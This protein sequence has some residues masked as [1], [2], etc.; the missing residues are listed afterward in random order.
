M[1]KFTFTKVSLLILF[2]TFVFLNVNSQTKTYGLI[3]KFS[4]SQ[5]NGYVLYS[6]FLSDTTFLINKC[7]Q[8]VHTWVN[9]SSPGMSLYL[10]PNGNLLKTG[11]YKD[12][13]FNHAGGKAGLIEEYDWDGNL[14]WKYVVMNDSLLHHHDIEI[15]PNGNI[16]VLAWH[17]ISEARALALGRKPEN[18]EYGTDKK[19]LWGEKIIEIKPLGTDSAEVVW[20]WDLFDHLIQDF[21]PLLPNFGFPS[22]FP[23]LM[24]INYALDLETFDWIHA[25][26]VAYNAELDQIVISAH[27]ICEF[28]II[29]HSTTIAESKSHSGGRYNKGGD[30][31]FRWGNPMAY[32]HGTIADRKL[33]RQ[34]DAHWIP[35]GYLDEG[36]IMLFNNGWG[37][38]TAYSTVEVIDIPDLSNNNY[39]YNL[40]MGP[41]SAHWKYKDSNPTNFYSQIIS[42][43]R[44]LPNGNTLICEGT[45]SLFFEVTPKGKIVWKYK[46]PYIGNVIQ[47]DGT[48]PKNGFVFR[49]SFYP[50]TFSGFKNKELSPKGTIEKKPLPYSCIYG[51]QEPKLVSLNPHLQKVNVM[52]NAKLVMRFDR[53]MI[54]G[55]NGVIEIY[56]NDLYHENILVNSQNVVMDNKNA[57]ITPS[58]P[59]PLNANIKV[60]VPA[61]SFKDSVGLFYSKI[62]SVSDWTFSTIEALPEITSFSPLHTQTNV[63]RNAKLIIDFKDSIFKGNGNIKVYE[64]Y[65][66]KEIINVNSN[67][68][69]IIGNKVII[70]LTDSFMPNHFV[71]VETDSCFR[72]E[73]G[74]KS[75]PITY[76]SWFFKTLDLLKPTSFNPAHLSVDVPENLKFEIEFNHPIQLGQAGS[77]KIFQNNDLFEELQYTDSKISIEGTKLKFNTSALFTKGAKISVDISNGLVLDSFNQTYNGIS[78]TNWN[79]K[80]NEPLSVVSVLE[81]KNIQVY[82][83][84]FSGFVNVVS[85]EP[86]WSVEIINMEGK[87]INLT[88]SPQQTIEFKQIPNGVYMIIINKTKVFKVLKAE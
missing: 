68:V 1:H 13:T 60:N 63:S 78:A 77:I 34:H 18:F 70:T 80:I 65:V 66:I 42:G 71:F 87:K 52:P 75:S 84:P 45:K 49:C 37:R 62:V 50:D 53:G 82:P 81:N 24:D 6:P 76:G 12:T 31:L 67:N 19:V 72:D 44:R 54:K 15:M 26:S 27:N 9:L 83:N 61:K 47:T 4:G 43:A 30:L 21:D 48:S 55:N 88:L 86:I 73:L 39:L 41:T 57:I 59:F 22:D 3:D 58:T 46:N 8:R 69:S 38:D 23:Q 36:K 16:L 29:D 7:G 17:Q 51:T 25:N 2:L 14:L 20:E 32:G 64:N 5:E 56:A 79:F 28:W 85:N 74:S 10:K 40:P 11:I 33:F 35:K